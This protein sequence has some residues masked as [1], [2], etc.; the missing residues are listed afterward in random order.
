M[1]LIFLV[2]CVVDFGG[3]VLL[4]FLVFCVVVFGG[5]VLLIF[6]VFCCGFW[7]VRVANLFSFLCCP[8]IRLY[9]MSSVLWYPLRFHIKTIFGSSLPP[10]VFR[11]AY[12]LFTLFVFACV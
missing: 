2:F 11:R 8:T 6:L 9:V 12:V 4:I 7:W 10:F 3:S 5:S 1:F